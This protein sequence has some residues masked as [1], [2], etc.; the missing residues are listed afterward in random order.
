MGMARF[1]IK[2]KLVILSLCSLAAL[3][4]VG[5]VGWVGVAYVGDS[6]GSI[7]ERMRS[8]NAITGMRIAQQASAS[9]SMRFDFAQYDALPDKQ[10]ALVEAQGYFSEVLS[11]KEGLDK[12]VDQYFADYK[13]LPK[14]GEEDALWQALEN[15]WREYG[16][17][18]RILHEQLRQLTA[19][20][21]WTQVS[22]E[23]GQLAWADRQFQFG[24]GKIGAQLDRLL[25][26]TIDYSEQTHAAGVAAS[27]A[28]TNAIGLIVAA[29][30]FG[31]AAF[32]WGIVRGVVGSLERMRKAIVHVAKSRDFTARIA[33]DGRDE[34]AQT[35]G[36]FDA[37]LE[38]M[39]VSLHEVLDAANRV[40]A[41]AQEMQ[42]AAEQ[43]SESSSS[44]SVEAASMATAIQQLTVGIKHISN[45]AQDAL[46]RASDAGA[47]AEQGKEIIA[48]TAA[49][50]DLI[51]DT[52]E[53][54]GETIG[55]V[56]RQSEQ[57]SIVIQVIKE[58]AEQ[59]N[60]L[61]LNA[62]IEAARAG[63]HGRGFAVVADEVRKLAERTARSTE[64][65]TQMVC[66][67]QSSAQNAV[68]D[69]ALVSDKVRTGKA[70]SGQ[71]TGRMVGIFEDA[72]RVTGAINDI[73][74]ALH[75]QS[76]VAHEVARRVEKVARMNE[77][78]SD[79]AKRSTTIAGELSGFARALKSAVDRFRL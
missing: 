50:M 75:E 66:Q 77:C 46:S 44:Q 53:H 54:A 57:I 72:E 22:H 37:L 62:A 17:A 79:S 74:S 18:R 47:G 26:L 6:L 39:Q 11:K 60:L 59:T 64:E 67:M 49:E 73:S 20:T 31:L 71:A 33:I 41:V 51:A 78:N 25:A 61:A 70:L 63:E 68:A 36:A 4:L 3:C 9:E 2:T 52:V 10:E 7:N 14:A 30:M 13:A 43:M 55:Q 8:V 1:T 29:A 21:D 35:A 56:G 12:R 15:D 32:A 42:A 69:M 76:S 24:S 65:I 40:G 34:A 58:I 45:S 5:A 38:T 16:E 27:A 28:A 48:R 23:L 19:V